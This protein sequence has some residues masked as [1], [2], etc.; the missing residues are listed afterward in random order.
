MY[1]SSRT[2]LLSLPR[3]IAI[4]VAGLIVCISLS[5]LAGSGDEGIRVERQLKET[6]GAARLPLFVQLFN[7][8][9]ALDSDQIEHYKREALGLLDRHPDEKIR[10]ALYDSLAVYYLRRGNPEQ[11]RIWVANTVALARDSINHNHMLTVEKLL[12]REA[13]NAG[14][15]EEARQRFKRGIALAQ[16]VDGRPMLITFNDLLAKTYFYEGDVDSAIKFFLE[17]S[18]HA[19]REN[20]R[21]EIGHLAFN[22][23]AMYQEKNLPVK[24]LEYYAITSKNITNISTRLDLFINVGNLQLRLGLTEQALK[25]Y[26]NGLKDAKKYASTYH[27]SHLLNNLANTFIAMGELDKAIR[28]IERA[29]DVAVTL[30]DNTTHCDNYFIYAK[31]LSRSGRFTEAEQALT[32]AEKH[33]ES[34]DGNRFAPELSQLRSQLLYNRGEFEKAFHIAEQAITDAQLAGREDSPTIL[35]LLHTRST[36][37]SALGRHQDA[38]RSLDDFVTRRTEYLSRQNAS[39]LAVTQAEIDLKSEEFKTRLLEQ[40]NSLQQAELLIANRQQQIYQLMVG[41]ATVI[42]IFVIFA[43][44]RIAGS[45]RHF[46]QLSETDMLTGIHNR[47]FAFAQGP[48]VLDDAVKHSRTCCTSIIDIDHFKSI[49]DS[50][51]HDAGDKVIRFVAEVLRAEVRSTDICARIGGEEFLIFMPDTSPANA[52]NVLERIR[53]RIGSTALSEI[54]NGSVTVSIGS[55]NTLESGDGNFEQLYKKADLALYDAKRGGRNRVVG[56]N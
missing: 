17:A 19:R 16:G 50:F 33:Q 2:G 39:A 38:Y 9:L 36:A 5:A 26:S 45:R 31:A 18:E 24:A 1:V 41:L 12:G 25:T 3:N 7:T 51:G 37:L 27:E 22:L 6:H 30:K 55:V 13:L 15:F 47:A 48:R 40:Q 44:I 4:L 10:F 53:A 29:I 32:R 43:A 20:N 11:T 42:L 49:N 35:D 34:M 21:T 8:H 46:K 54:E 56:V 52:A 28:H 23:G 14:R